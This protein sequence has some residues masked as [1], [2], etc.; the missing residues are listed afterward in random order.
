MFL[1]TCERRSGVIDF[2]FKSGF[3]YILG[4]DQHTTHNSVTTVLSRRAV[5]VFRTRE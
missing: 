3:Q 1:G 4:P 2:D 5:A